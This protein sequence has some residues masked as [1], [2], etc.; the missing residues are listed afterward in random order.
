M[1]VCNLLVSQFAPFVEVMISGFCQ[2]SDE[3]NKQKKKCALSSRCPAERGCNSSPGGRDGS[4]LF[5]PLERQPQHGVLDQGTRQGSGSYFPP[6]VWRGL[7]SPIPG[8]DRVPEDHAYGRKYFHEE[9]HSPGYRALPLLCSDLP[10]R[11]LDEEH[12]GGRF[13]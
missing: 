5:V 9:R 10:S 13:R 4:R 1:F 11:P 8:E 3:L 7:S 2:D 12:S 6:R